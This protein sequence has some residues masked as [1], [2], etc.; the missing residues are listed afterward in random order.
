ML[1]LL[2]LIA[3]V[4]TAAF[5]DARERRIYNW[6]TYPGM[7][8]GLGLAASG[9]L[10]EQMAPEAAARWQPLVGWLPLLD[11]LGGFL[12][13]GFIMVLSFVFFPVGGGDVKLLAMVGALTGLER[14]LEVLLWT[15]VLGGCLGLTI[16]IWRVGA[17]SLVRRAGQMAYSAVT[18]GARLSLPAAEKRELELPV[19]LGPCAAMAVAAVLLPWPWNA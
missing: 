15:F 4:L 13:C 18:L 2:L 10:V 3:L 17:I 8:V 19:F 11:A 9:A 6:T 16:L 14:G 12:L 5:T 7:L 1:S